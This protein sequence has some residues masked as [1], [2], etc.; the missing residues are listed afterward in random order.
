MRYACSLLTTYSTSSKVSRQGEGYLR[1]EDRLHSPTKASNKDKS[2]Q[3]STSEQLRGVSDYWTAAEVDSFPLLVEKYGTNWTAISIELKTKTASMVK[4]YFD[5]ELS[6]DLKH[7]GIIIAE[8]IEDG[9]SQASIPK[10]DDQGAQA[11][12]GTSSPG[13]QSGGTYFSSSSE[14]IGVAFPEETGRN[15]MT[16]WD[17]DKRAGSFKK[18]TSIPTRRE[19]PK[20]SR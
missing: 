8:A 17:P 15:G 6:L 2:M 14:S 7:R 10:A 18:H 3:D 20:R 9:K 1:Q 4:N 19:A 16:I 5:R 12:T 13:P 11:I